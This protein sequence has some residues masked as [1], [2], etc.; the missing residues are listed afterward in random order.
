MLR[1]P[2]QGGDE[3][4]LEVGGCLIAWEWPLVEWVCI[5]I[6]VIIT[7]DCTCTLSNCS[8]GSSQFAFLLILNKLQYCYNLIYCC[9]CCCFWLLGTALLQTSVLVCLS[10]I[11]GGMIQI[12]MLRFVFDSLNT[13]KFQMEM[14]TKLNN[15]WT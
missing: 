7:W 12:Q 10:S 3:E 8:T 6:P 4:Y 5:L 13:W 2:I 9:C 1:D 14:I 15:R 11:H